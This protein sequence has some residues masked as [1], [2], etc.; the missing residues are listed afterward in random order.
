MIVKKIFSMWMLGILFVG[1]TF[2][3]A[4]PAPSHFR[5]PGPRVAKSKRNHRGSKHKIIRKK[6]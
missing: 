3:Q 4:T 5:K 6:R 2:A 1:A